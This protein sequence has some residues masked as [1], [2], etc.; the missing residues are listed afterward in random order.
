VIAA[1]ALGVLY[2]F[3]VARVR[4][5]PRGRSIA[6]GLG[7][8]TLAVAL[9]MPDRGLPDHMAQHMLLVVVA[10]PLLVLGAPHVLALRALRG[11]ARARVARVLATRVL[12]SPAL[13]FACFAAMML[14][15]HLTPFFDLAER[16]PLAH[17]AEHVLLLSTAVLFWVPVVAAAPAR[18]L[19]PL[20]SVGYLFAAM[21]PM[22]VVGAAFGG[23]A[24]AIMWV[25]G[26]YALLA[27]VL[28][29]VWAAL[30][31]EERR[32]RARETYG[33]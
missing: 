31:G 8:L 16:H 5:W 23:E 9:Q 3:A 15:A 17:G 12:S 26:G 21:A 19:G 25:G 30:S 28:V 7:L 32:Q 11:E 14:G 2:A 29:A 20:A 13:S 27:T 10:A 22:G 4:R 18:R 1:I 24:G 6:F 33:R